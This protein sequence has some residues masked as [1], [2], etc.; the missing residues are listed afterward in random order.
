MSVEKLALKGDNYQ[1]IVEGYS[2]A[3]GASETL[4]KSRW[5]YGA[6]ELNATSA[7]SCPTQTDA[8]GFQRRGSQSTSHSTINRMGRSVGTPK[9]LGGEGAGGSHVTLS[10]SIDDH[11]SLG[12]NRVF[13]VRL[14]MVNRGKSTRNFTL[15]MPTT[16][17]NAFIPSE[18]SGVAK[19]GGGSAPFQY[20]KVS[21]KQLF[22]AWTQNDKREATMVCLEKK[23]VISNLAPN[24]CYETRLHFIILKSHLHTIDKLRLIDTDTQQVTILRRVLQLYV[25]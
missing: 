6:Q 21:P 24:R 23:I 11:D 19:T 14:F 16:Y 17:N 15:E 13:A 12:A 25:P 1:L 22:Q 9:L 4:I 10:F 7:V 3:P 18:D 8:P 20:L 5:N 2:L